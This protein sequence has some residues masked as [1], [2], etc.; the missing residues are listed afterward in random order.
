MD[1]ATATLRSVTHSRVTD[2]QLIF[3]AIHADIGCQK[4]NLPARAKAN[5][6]EPALRQ[7][8]A[9]SQYGV[10]YENEQGTTPPR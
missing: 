8:T 1:G 6:S 9:I 5:N 4:N 7:R 10:R 3:T 2:E